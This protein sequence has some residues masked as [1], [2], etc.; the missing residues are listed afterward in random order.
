M[1]ESIGMI[2]TLKNAGQFYTSA[3]VMYNVSNK[4]KLAKSALAAALTNTVL[5]LIQISEQSYQ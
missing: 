4:P 5:Q 1:L 2:A 3:G